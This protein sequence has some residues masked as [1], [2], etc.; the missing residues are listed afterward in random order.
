MDDRTL[1]GYLDDVSKGHELARGVVWSSE[2]LARA[3]RLPDSLGKA[4]L[5]ERIHRGARAPQHEQFLYELAKLLAEHPVI[6]QLEQS[7]D[8]TDDQKVQAR[9]LACKWSELA[10]VLSGQGEGTPE[11]N[12]IGLSYSHAELLRAQLREAIVVSEI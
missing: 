1:L 3:A 5:I 10:K 11:G 9:E 4:A 6:T 2:H 12:W 8:W 7:W